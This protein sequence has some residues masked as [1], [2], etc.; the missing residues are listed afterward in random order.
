MSKR[1]RSAYDKWYISVFIVTQILYNGQPS[2]GG[3]HS[4]FGVMTSLLPKGTVDF[5]SFRVSSIFLQGN[6]DRSHKL[7]NIVAFERDICI[8]QV[9]LEWCYV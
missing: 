2:H 8:M 4:I 9:L 3:D 6:P 1:P 5:S 7:W